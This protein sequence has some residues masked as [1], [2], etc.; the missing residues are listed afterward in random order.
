MRAWICILFLVVAGLRGARAADVVSNAMS[1]ARFPSLAAAVAAA[2]KGD[3][4]VLIGNE[5]L[6]STLTIS[7]RTLSIV[8][9]GVERTIRG[10]TNC[11]YDMVLLAGT[12]TFLTLGKSGGSDATPTLIFDGGK[13]AGVSNLYDMVLM[14]GSHLTMHPG[15]VL[16]NLAS[17]DTGP[18]NNSGGVF[19]MRGGRIEGNS[20]PYGGAINNNMGEVWI[21]GGSITGNLAN[22]GGGIYNQAVELYEGY[23]VAY[24]GKSTVSGG[25]IANNAAY[26]AG[27]GIFNMGEMVLSGG[28]VELNSAPTGG[29]VYHYNGAAHGMALK[30]DALV[31]SNTASTGSGIF[32]NNDNNTWLTLAEGGRVVPSNDVCMATNLSPLVLAGPLSGRGTAVQ[33]TPAIYSTNTSVLGTVGT[34]NLWI[35]SNYYGKFTVTPKSGTAWYVNSR[36]QLSLTNPVLDPLEVPEIGEATWGAAGLEMAVDPAYVAWDGV[37]DCATNMIGNAWNFVPLA[38]NAY[39]VTNGRVIVNS[40]VPMGVFRMRSR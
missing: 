31:V 1:G 5:I 6:S 39:A 33:L 23:I 11:S 34:S 24:V 8:S 20:A 13:G 26:Q 19:E 36:G 29:G 7:N 27:G 9:D 25:K 21:Y 30:G 10:S 37:L 40:D 16:R 3:E 32:Y 35:V 4:L 15:V 17:L 14:N 28:R 18:V 2:A 38:T 22:F 12:N